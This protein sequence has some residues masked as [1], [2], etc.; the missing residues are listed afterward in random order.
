MIRLFAPAAALIAALVALPLAPLRAAPARAP[1]AQGLAAYLPADSR[2]ILELTDAP[3]ALQCLS[4]APLHLLGS[5]TEERRTAAASAL[6][7]PLGLTSED[8]SAL[9]ASMERL[10]FGSFEA[11]GSDESEASEGS[12]LIGRLR[13]PAA[14]EPLRRS[15]RLTAAGSASGAEL[16]EVQKSAVALPEKSLTRAVLGPWLAPEAQLAWLP[17]QRLVLVGPQPLVQRVLGGLGDK[18]AADGPLHE[19]LRRAPAEPIVGAAWADE[20]AGPTDFTPSPVTIA[21]SCNAAGLTTRMVTPM[22]SLP[23]VEE[24][25]RSMARKSPSPQKLPAGTLAFVAM[26]T[27]WVKPVQGL[28][29]TFL[30]ALGGPKAARDMDRGWRALRKQ[31]GL[32]AASPADL[33]GAEAT[34]SLYAPTALTAEQ[35]DSDEH[36]LQA[37]QV[38]VLSVALATPGPVRKAL[39]RSIKLVQEMAG[40]ETR[41]VSDRDGLLLRFADAQKSV[42]RVA[43]TPAGA[44]WVGHGLEKPVAAALAAT[45]RGPV[46]AD[47]PAFRSAR[48][49]LGDR[50]Q[51]LMWADATRL[52]P[53]LSAER[54]A[55]PL[56]AVG[57]E[58]VGS[59]AAR[60]RGIAMGAALKIVVTSDDGLVGQLVL[61]NAEPVTMPMLAEMLRAGRMKF[62]S[63]SSAPA[64][65]LPEAVEGTSEDYKEVAPEPPALELDPAPSEL[66]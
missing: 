12:L 57:I 35:V 31:L 51:V 23:I 5:S 19:A 8:A 24:V 9:V 11:A 41:I 48:A 27:D 55:Q 13:Q 16:F 45:L 22:Q 33:V 10:A 14:F 53:A 58:S 37:G 44:L 46:L 25:L 6:A 26:T 21:A 61:H 39:G 36:R 32:K 64:G 52:L 60:L 56:R 40:K 65:D 42:M 15:A 49:A 59:D 18:S 28:V 63:S 29:G 3:A 43:V 17:A 20:K 50:P 38:T 62:S 30:G 66:E 7:E 1:A 47:L 34:V 2:L 4:Q 54:L